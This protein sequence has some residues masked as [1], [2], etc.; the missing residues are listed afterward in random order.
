M[1]AEH[2]LREG[3]QM[4]WDCP[5]A[6]QTVDGQVGPYQL[7]VPLDSE[8]LQSWGT[9]LHHCVGSYDERMARGVT[10]IIGV[11]EGHN[12]KACIEVDPK[13]RVIRQFRG[14]RNQESP[15]EMQS[16]VR[17]HLRKLGV[18]K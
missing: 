11:L 4:S 8:T 14:V 3:T 13:S 10:W 5:K 6:L 9:S 1:L 18:T 12:I 17:A 7:Q 2:Q 15:E 16:T